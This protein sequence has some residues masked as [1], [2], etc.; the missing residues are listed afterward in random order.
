MYNA[1][2]DSFT[3]KPS[4]VIAYTVEEGGTWRYMMVDGKVNLEHEFNALYRRQDVMSL[5]VFGL[6]ASH[7]RV[8]VK[9]WSQDV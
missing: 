3:N 9:E 4:Y 2:N 6:N 8:I 7:T 5:R 1:K